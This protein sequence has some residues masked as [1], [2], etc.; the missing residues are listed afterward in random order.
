LATTLPENT[1]LVTGAAGF[2]G[3]NIACDL[4]HDHTVVVCDSFGTE[5]TWRYLAAALVHDIVRPQDVLAWLEEHATSVSAIVHMGAI[6]STTETDV[7]KIVANNVRLTLD[8]WEY[9]ARTGT[10]FVY[11][12]SAATYGDGSNG[13]VDDD[14]PEALA[15]LQPLNA[16][17]WSKHLV[18]R[19][20]ADDV[21]RGRPVPPR[22]A[23][24]KFFNVYGP[25]EGHKG[26]MRSVVHQI[27]PVAAAGQPVRLFKSD[28]PDYADG[29]QLRD[30]IYVKDCAAVVRNMLEAPEL[31]GIYNVGTGAARS[32]ADLAGAVFAAIEAEPQIE[33]FDMPEALRGRYQ[34][35]TEADT[36]KLVAA[37]LAP[38]FHDLESG[39]AD[40]VRSYLVRELAAG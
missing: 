17:G 13:F 25:N 20:I 24:L 14:S 32:F 27:Y 16:Y 28:N 22:W 11:A 19:R 39:V 23:G 38:R 31:S 8:L 21:T 40:Y 18:D 9:S 6:S 2:I 15:R 3:S 36:S 29:G 26:S 30:F 37:G 5:P 7:D 12:S 10:T 4:A 33:Y 1:V 35:F 34:Y